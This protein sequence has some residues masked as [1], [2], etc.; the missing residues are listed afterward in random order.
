MMTDVPLPMPKPRS[1]SRMVRRIALLLL[2]AAVIAA[3]AWLFGTERGRA[4]LNRDFIH[5]LGDVVRLW[6]DDNP[7]MTIAIFVATYVICAILLL[8]VWWLQMLAGFAF[9]LWWGMAWVMIASTCGA[10]ATAQ[11]S[12]W[13][14]EE[15]VHE[16]IVGNGKGAKR[17]RHIIETADR[18]GL[19]VVFISRLS[20][21]VPYGISNYLFGLLEIRYR[22]IAIGTAFGGVPVYVG[23]VAAGSEPAWLVSWQFWTIIVG[24]NLAIL[25]PLI[26]HSVRSGRR[27]KEKAASAQEGE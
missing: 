26:V 19:L 16:R 20:Y 11:V 3:S 21:P 18:N 4:H 7:F 25:I 24:V 12:R 5:H 22:D 14:G 17:L 15:W 9:G 27:A 1:R 2:V 23:W 13:L 10:L 8:P 6:M